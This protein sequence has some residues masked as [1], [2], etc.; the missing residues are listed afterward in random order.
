MSETQEHQSPI[1]KSNDRFTGMVKWFNNKAGF[2]FI[3]VCGEGQYKGKDIFVHYSSIRVSNLQYKYLVQGEYIDFT[4]VESDSDEHEYQATDVCGVNGG[5]I[6]CETR[7]SM[8]QTRNIQPH[9]DTTQHRVTSQLRQPPREYVARNLRN[10]LVKPQVKLQVKE[11]ISQSDSEGFTTVKRN[12]RQS[13]GP[14][15]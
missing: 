10:S 9:G 8:V 6:M 13:R 12:S 14:K 2:G 11:P 15:V 3:T 7:Q 1:I 4:I 5:S